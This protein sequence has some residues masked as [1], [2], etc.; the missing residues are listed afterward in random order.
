MKIYGVYDGAAK[1]FLPVFQAHNHEH[2]KRMFQEAIGP[3]WVHRADYTLMCL[4]ELNNETGAIQQDGTDLVMQ[5]AAIPPEYNPNWFPPRG[6][7]FE[8]LK[9]APFEEAYD[10]ATM[11][12]AK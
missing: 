9:D 12:N 4:G 3:K 11:E 7:N 2:A 5:G 8:T 1:Y 6:D 10:T